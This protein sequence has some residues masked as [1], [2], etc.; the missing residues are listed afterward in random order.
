MVAQL[1]VRLKEGWFD[2]GILKKALNVVS[3][4]ASVINK[5]GPVA[6]M[7]GM[8][9][10]KAVA[11]PMGSGVVDMVKKGQAQNA[12]QE[13]KA[14]IAPKK[15]SKGGAT[16]KMPDGSMMKGASHK[17]GHGGRVKKMSHGGSASKRADGCAVKGKTKGRMV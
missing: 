5:S 17:M 2:M 15:M 14:R 4:A 8:E 16:H 3:P 6:K 12:L 7:L 13:G 10:K 11:R 1:E 9:Q